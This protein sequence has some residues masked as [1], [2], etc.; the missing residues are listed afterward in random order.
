MA[1]TQ[2]QVLEAI[3]GGQVIVIATLQAQLETAQEQL[4]QQQAILDQAPTPDR[5]R[6]AQ[7]PWPPPTSTRT[8]F[9]PPGAGPFGEAMTALPTGMA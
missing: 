7:P 1:R 6:P 9:P 5:P 8:E 4:T 3:I 2:Q